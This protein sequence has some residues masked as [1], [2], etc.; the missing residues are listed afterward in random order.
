MSR[1]R[2]RAI[3]VH[4]ANI[5][6]IFDEIADLLDIQGANAFRV[7]A[8]RNGARSIGELGSDIQMLIQRGTKLT[9]IPGIGEDLA[10]K[11]Q[12]IIET[13]QCEFLERLHEEIPPA[14][15]ELLKIPGL[16]PKRVKL[17]WHALHIHT[18]EQLLHAAQEGQIQQLRG[19]GEKIEQKIIETAQARLNRARRFKH[20]VAGQY[21]EALTLSLREVEGVTQVTV[22]GSFRRRRET[23][24]DL[25]I[26]VTA[27]SGDAVMDRFVTDKEVKEVL[28]HGPTRSSVL[29]KIGLQVDLR[30]VPHES[31]GAALVYFTG[32]KAHNIAIRRI[33]QNQGLKLNEYGVFKGSKRIAGETEESVYKAIGLPWIPPELRED[34]GEIQAA[35][36]GELPKPAPSIRGGK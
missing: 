27:E 19:F 29:L 11:I 34:N 32:S 5:E 15:R 20:A 25:D 31:Y 1:R 14:I 8:Y 26:V 10:K 13:G 22:A 18:L 21:A 17:L 2:S 24:G 16:G 28:A 3:P 4:N 36:A 30:V 12:E 35:L 7:R 23:V 9:D 6:A 33:A